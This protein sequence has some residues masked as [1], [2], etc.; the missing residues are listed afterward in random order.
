M[1]AGSLPFA[2]AVRIVR[3][4]GR[5]MQEA[6][7]QGVGAMAAFLKLPEGKLDEILCAAPPK[8]KSSAPPISI[9]RTR[10]SSPATPEP[11][12]AQGE[13]AKAAGAKRAIPLPVSAPFHCALMKPAQQ[14]LSADLDAAGFPT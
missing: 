3:N 8:A 7:P 12:T 6:V 9:P 11:S 13:L 1:A 4:R 14:R 5:Y 10:S 2:D